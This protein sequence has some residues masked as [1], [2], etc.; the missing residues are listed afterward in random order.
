MINGTNCYHLGISYISLCSKYTIRGIYCQ[1]ISIDEFSTLYQHE[2]RLPLFLAIV[3]KITLYTILDKMM[4][5]VEDEMRQEAEEQRRM[6]R[7]AEEEDRR[8]RQEQRDRDNEQ[9][10]RECE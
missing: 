4:E 2:S 8:E 5:S 9:L 10:D 6:D 1:I 7:E 3:L